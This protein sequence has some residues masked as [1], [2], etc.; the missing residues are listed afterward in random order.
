MEPVGRNVTGTGRRYVFEGLQRNRSTLWDNL[1]F[2]EQSFLDAVASEREAADMDVNASDLIARFVFV[3]LQYVQLSFHVP[4]SVTVA[5][6]C[7]W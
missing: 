7:F 3:C 5:L 4:V 6:H 1:E 2:W